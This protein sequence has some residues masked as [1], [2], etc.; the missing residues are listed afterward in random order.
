[1]AERP[2]GRR[3]PARRERRGGGD[4]RRP[5]DARRRARRPAAARAAPLLRVGRD[6]RQPRSFQRDPPA[7]DRGDRARDVPAGMKRVAVALLIAL[8]VAPAAAA[9]PPRSG[10]VHVKVPP[11]TSDVDYG[12]QL[13]GGNCITCHGADG[14]GRRGAIPPPGRGGGGRGTGKGGRGGGP[15]P[16]PAPSWRGAGPP[17]AVFFRRRG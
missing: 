4:Q 14:R 15:P 11:G 3:P 10:I 8:A 12:A 16:A 5:G 17:P 9:D 2:D 1:M 13:Y 6:A 7:G